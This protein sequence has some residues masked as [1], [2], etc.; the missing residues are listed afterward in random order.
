M[1]LNEL[2][3]GWADWL[4]ERAEADALADVV[5][6]SIQVM[7]PCCYD[8]GWYGYAREKL[9]DAHRRARA[10]GVCDAQPGEAEWMT[11]SRSERSLSAVEAYLSVEIGA[12]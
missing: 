1:K 8:C 12:D 7:D 3:E 6:W 10:A 2:A 11:A 4:D 9:R 5:Y